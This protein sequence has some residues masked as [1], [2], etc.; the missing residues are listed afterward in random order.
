MKL[1]RNLIAAL[2][3]IFALALAGSAMA[4][5]NNVTVC[6]SGTVNAGM[7]VTSRTTGAVLFTTDANGCGTFNMAADPNGRDMSALVSAGFVVRSPQLRSIAISTSVCSTSGSAGNSCAEPTAA[8]SP[9][10]ADSS[11]GVSCTCAGSLSGVPV[12]GG[13]TKSASSI[14]VNVTAVT[15]VTASCP[16]VDCTIIHQ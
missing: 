6:Q 3:L 11:Y 2:M 1:Y 14:V 16:E 9:A 15:A 7:Q 8:I 10:F 13:I 4:T 12:I 5:T